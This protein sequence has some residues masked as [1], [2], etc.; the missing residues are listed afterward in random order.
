M[1]AG[2]GDQRLSCG[3]P[4]VRGSTGTD[5]PG[6]RTLY[7]VQARPFSPPRSSWCAPKTSYEVQ[8]PGTSVPVRLE[9]LVYSRDGL[10]A[11]SRAYRY[12]VQ[13]LGTKTTH[14]DAYGI[15]PL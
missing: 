1:Y 14:S 13:V 9:I 12:S 6:T 4:R 15:R 11:P 8:V 10:D 2:A 3:Y 5:V 7:G